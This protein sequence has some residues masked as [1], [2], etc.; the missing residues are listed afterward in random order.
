MKDMSGNEIENSFI[1]I[2]FPTSFSHSRQASYGVW[3]SVE[4]F[5]ESGGDF[6]S[7]LSLSVPRSV[8][9][10]EFFIYFKQN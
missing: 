5:L 10:E 1:K 4:V 8:P 2:S 9:R 7:S 6:S 3:E